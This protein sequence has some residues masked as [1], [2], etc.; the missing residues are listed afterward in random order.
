MRTRRVHRLPAS[1]PASTGPRRTWGAP[2]QSMAQGYFTSDGLQVVEPLVDVAAGHGRHH[3]KESRRSVFQSGW[4]TLILMQRGGAQSN[5]MIWR[6]ALPSASSSMP[7]L[8][9]SSVIV[10][11]TSD[12]TGSRP[13]RHS[14]TNRGMSREG[15]AEPR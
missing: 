13:A 7:A 14:S 4:P 9:S 15:T 11:V 5:W 2:R 1:S 10:A 8:M 3:T 12:S 6:T